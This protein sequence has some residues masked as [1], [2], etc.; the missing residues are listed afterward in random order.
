VR[1][2]TTAFQAEAAKVRGAVPVWFLKADFG[3]PTPGTL[4]LWTGVGEKTWNGD[5]YLS[6]LD[7]VQM[8]AGAE[9]AD[10][11]TSPTTFTLAWRD[12]ATARDLIAA[13]LQARSGGQVHVAKGWLDDAGQIVVDPIYTWVGRIS[14]PVIQEGR[15]SDT[16]GASLTIQ[17]TAEEYQADRDRSHRFRIT[18]ASQLEFDATD[19]GLAHQASLSSEDLKW[20]YLYFKSI[21]Y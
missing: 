1:D 19:T 13:T 2:S 9:N 18:L 10:G 15:P 4:F 7:L 20:G 6:G 8:K 12:K 11:A 17:V 14:A 16:E 3:Q 21:G 5:P